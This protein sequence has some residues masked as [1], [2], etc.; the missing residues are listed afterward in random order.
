[1]NVLKQICACVCALLAHSFVAAQT[2]ETEQ[3][4]LR[5]F[6]HCV[7]RLPDARVRVHW[8]YFNRTKATLTRALGPSNRATGVV[9]GTQPTQFPPGFLLQT[10]RSVC[11]AAESCSWAIDGV[12]ATVDKRAHVCEPSERVAELVNPAPGTAM[13]LGANFWRLGWQDPSEYF[14]PQANF[15][16]ENQSP[17]QLQLLNELTPYRVLRFMDWNLTND[18]QNPQSNW[19]TRQTKGQAQRDAVAYEWQIN[20]CNRALK[21]Y[22]LTVPH[23][24]S[25][26][27]FAQLAQ[28]V[29]EQLDPRLRVYVEWSNE[30]WNGSFPQQAFA[31]ARGSQLRLPGKDA[32]MAYQVQQSLR[33]FEAFERVFGANNPRVVKVL[34]GQAAF[35]GPCRAQLAALKDPAIN[36]KH[37]QPS[38]YAIAPYIYGSSVQELRG[39]GLT[40][41]KAWVAD[42]ASCAKSAGLPLIAY[43]GG[44]DSFALG[45]PACERLQRNPGMRALYAE[46]PDTLAA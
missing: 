1:M 23:A 34:A 8:G 35:D 27:Y 19:T 2:A 7:E 30:L 40:Q 24:A 6:V 46:L 33:L 26:E 37:T 36:P 42:A 5:P 41:A 17:W 11:T 38:V 29:K 32:A 43:E 21:D 31:R 28:L 20:L 16:A 25:V 12:A 14:L 10:F 39:E 13:F 3:V 45:Q 15:A 9:E 4:P 18:A 44:Q 22:W